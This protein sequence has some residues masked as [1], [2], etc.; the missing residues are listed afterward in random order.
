MTRETYL[1]H[2]VLQSAGWIKVAEYACQSREDAARKEAELR[3]SFP[4]DTARFE[5]R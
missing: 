5:V 1:T 4:N 3:A 2:Y